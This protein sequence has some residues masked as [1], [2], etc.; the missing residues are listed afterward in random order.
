MD[1]W[2]CSALSRLEWDKFASAKGREKKKVFVNSQDACLERKFSCMYEKQGIN[3]SYY[4]KT[5]CAVP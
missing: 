1:S 4:R 2:Q 3:S 5:W